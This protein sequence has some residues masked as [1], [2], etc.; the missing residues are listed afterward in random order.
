MA[1]I[2]A[3]PSEGTI[4]TADMAQELSVVTKNLGICLQADKIQGRVGVS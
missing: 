2:L 4:L 1:N 3:A